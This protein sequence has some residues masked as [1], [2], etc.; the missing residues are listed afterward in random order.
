M[1]GT[2]LFYLTIMIGLFVLYL[3]V[4]K[5]CEVYETKYKAL[6]MANMKITD[7]SDDEEL[8]QK[9]LDNLNNEEEYNNEK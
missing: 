7:I 1:S 9:L 6:A 2:Q 8:R 4:T 3:I 5:I